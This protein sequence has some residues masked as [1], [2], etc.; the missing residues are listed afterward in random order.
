MREDKAGGTVAAV[1]RAL[2]VLQAFRPQ[3]TSLTLADLEERTGLYKSTILRLAAT[4]ENFGYLSR[5]GDGSY[6][7]GHAPLRLAAFY[8]RTTQ[9]SERILPFM[10]RLV[11]ETGESASF[12]IRQADMAVCLYRIDSAHIVR[13]HVRPGD[14]H[15]INV[16]ASGK[17]IV[18][19]ELSFSRGELTPDYAC[20]AVPVFDRKGVAGSVSLSGP[21]N[22][23]GTRA[24]STMKAALA[25]AASDISIALGADAST[26]EVPVRRAKK[27]G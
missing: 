19:K 17:A 18:S 15:P 9:P 10:E 24:V 21:T 6:R 1:E 5:A 14:A 2:E 20:M 26:L 3:D 11:K 12:T 22:R 23:F 25:R 27:A 7:I 16:G 8:Q 13:D 4:L